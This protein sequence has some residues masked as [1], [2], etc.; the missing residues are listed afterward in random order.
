MDVER[1]LQAPTLVEYDD[2]LT[3]PLHGFRDAQDY[4]A[5]ADARRSLADIRVPVLF[6]QAADDRFLSPGAI[7][8]AVVDRNPRA[9]RAGALRRV[10]DG[11]QEMVAA[12][13]IARNT[14]RKTRRVN[15]RVA[16]RDS[17]RDSQPGR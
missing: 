5:R 15:V 7:P 10:E 11:E 12:R 6:L 13:E 1:V 8:E 17:R 2:A 14:F 3:A 16:E 9:V 4:Y